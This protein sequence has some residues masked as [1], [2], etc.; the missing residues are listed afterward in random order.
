MACRLPFI[1]T[2]APVIYGDFNLFRIE[3]G[4]RCFGFRTRAQLLTSLRVCQVIGCGFCCLGRA[5]SR[6]DCQS[7]GRTAAE[8]RPR[9]PQA[10]L[11]D[12]VRS[13]TAGIF[14]PPESLRNYFTSYGNENFQRNY[15]L[16]REVFLFLLI[17]LRGRN[18][19]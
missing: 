4:E 14:F 11:S 18:F 8:D 5:A 13:T 17:F 10:Q 15:P 2:K 3:A 7:Y 9:S 1:N 19:E 12:R 6:G 16:S